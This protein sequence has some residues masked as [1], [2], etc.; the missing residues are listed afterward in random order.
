MLHW[1]VILT[2]SDWSD[3]VETKA[4]ESKALRS[5][6]NQARGPI[7]GHIRLYEVCRKIWEIVGW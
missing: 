1:G 3:F 2:K 6:S 4:K 5:F 7:R